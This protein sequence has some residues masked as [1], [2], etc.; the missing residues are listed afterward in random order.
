[1]TIAATRSGK[2]EGVEHD[3]VLVFRGIPYAAPPVGA[4]RW[5]PPAR[6]DAWDGVR[7]ATAVL[8][9][10]PRRPTFAMTHDAR[11]RAAR[12]QRGQPLPQRVDARRATTRAAGDGVDPRR[13]V[14]L[15]LGRHAVVRRHAVRAARRRRRRHDQLP[16][17]SVRVPAPRR[18]VRSRVRRLR[19]R[20]HP[21]PGRRA[22]VGARLH[23]RVRRRSR[24]TSRCSASRP[25]A[26]ASA[27]CSGCPP[28]AGCSGRRSPK[29]ARRRGGRHARARPG[30]RST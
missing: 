23:R 27:R 3:G 7:D 8:R 29:A 25:A 11:R 10:S 19:Q 2:I 5:L 17:R 16:P 12:D 9:R 20:G 14:H 4:R 13:R 28:R 22:R 1:M 21:R 26:A 30:S 6:E 15:R 24:R 18:P